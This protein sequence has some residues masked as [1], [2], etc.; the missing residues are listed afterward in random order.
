MLST[1]T[2]ARDRGFAQ[3]SLAAHAQHTLQTEICAQRVTA[4]VNT[5]EPHLQP[6]HLH[7]MSSSATITANHSAATSSL[8]TTHAST[9][10]YYKSALFTA[11]S[12]IAALESSLNTLKSQLASS[13]T[14]C[15]F[16]V[17]RVCDLDRDSR[18]HA[19]ELDAT[20]RAKGDLEK[21]VGRLRGEVEKL[22]V[23]RRVV[24][25][26]KRK[27]GR[28]PRNLDAGVQTDTEDENEDNDACECTRRRAA[29]REAKSR[30]QKSFSNIR[31]PIEESGGK[32]GGRP[33]HP[34]LAPR[35]VRFVDDPSSDKGKSVARPVSAPP[36]LSDSAIRQGWEE[37]EDDADLYDVSISDVRRAL[38]AHQPNRVGDGRRERMQQMRD[39][40]R[41]ARERLERKD[42]VERLR[43]DYIDPPD[44][45]DR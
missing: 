17:K 8:L 41:A 10:S 45:G 18:I 3:T 28:G 9:L 26:E 19:L 27:T 43:E 34:A 39:N 38:R 1:L 12:R 35:R 13:R 37:M 22:R 5:S 23:A 21:E 40:L 33:A 36:P 15:E 7:P 6:H 42:V 16:Y 31:P 11:Q 4:D 30:R 32:G 44:D 2:P 24:G 25:G 20:N 29:L 14:E